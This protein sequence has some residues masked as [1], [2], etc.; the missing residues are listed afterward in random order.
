MNYTPAC[1]HSSL[2]AN[3]IP[4]L[5]EFF[6]HKLVIVAMVIIRSHFSWVLFWLR[7]NSPKANYEV[8][9]NIDN[10]EYTETKYKKNSMNLI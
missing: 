3:Q 8:R 9:M 4:V 6:V 5:S 1:P 2:I 10:K 7:D